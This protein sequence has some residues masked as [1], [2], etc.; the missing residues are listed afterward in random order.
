MSEAMTLPQAKLVIDTMTE[1]SK[2]RVELSRERQ[3][4]AELSSLIQSWVRRKRVELILDDARS[5]IAGPLPDSCRILAE[6]M[7]DSRKNRHV[8]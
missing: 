6:S 2:L 3:R 5:S 7:P 4:R 1:C 8:R